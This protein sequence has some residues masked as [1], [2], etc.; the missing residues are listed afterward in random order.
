MKK[1]ILIFLLLS[2]YLVSFSEIEQED[3][4]KNPLREVTTYTTARIREKAILDLTV[5]KL[6]IRGITYSK[7]EDGNMVFEINKTEGIIPKYLVTT[8]T[9]LI[10]RDIKVNG[11]NINRDTKGK[12]LEFTYKEDIEP[13]QEGFRQMIESGLY[14]ENLWD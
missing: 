5:E 13:A 7:L 6:N 14:P 3:V 2:S 10:P 11:K 8:S 1:I 9:D 12:K 4:T